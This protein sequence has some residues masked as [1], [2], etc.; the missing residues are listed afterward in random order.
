MPFRR[1]VV[2]N[3]LQLRPPTCVAQLCISEHLECTTHT[4]V[5]LAAEHNTVQRLTARKCY[6]LVGTCCDFGLASH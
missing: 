2:L 1:Q 4:Y 6:K 5:P 3:E